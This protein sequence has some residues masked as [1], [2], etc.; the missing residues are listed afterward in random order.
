MIQSRLTILTIVLAAAG[1]AMLSGCGMEG[2]RDT[3]LFSDLIDNFSPPT[4]SEAARDAF[5]VYDADKRRNSINLLASS[6]FGGL[7]PYVRTY[8]LL[9][10]DSD[11]S[12]RAACVKALGMHGEVSDAQTIAGLLADSS[13]F[14]RWEAAKALQRIH[15]PVAIE[16]LRRTLAGDEDDDVRMAA[17]DALGQYANTAVF[18]SLIGALTDANFAVALAAR[19]SLHTLTG[20]DLGNEPRDWM[21]WADQRRD[22]LFA[23]QRVYV[24]HPYQKPPGTFQKMNPWY[25]QPAPE[26]QMPVGLDSNSSPNTQQS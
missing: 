17:A 14:V 23:G 5:N 26:A 1:V 7:S 2:G 3:T 21:A 24:Y 9:L 13:A 18:D 25:E 15:N 20:Q 6:S 10:D 8:R 22:D 11:P 16:P 4:P 19:K 12:V